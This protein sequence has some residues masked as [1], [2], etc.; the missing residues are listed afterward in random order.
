M[1]FSPGGSLESVLCP[2]GVRFNPSTAS[3]GPASTVDSHSGAAEP[4]SG[5]ILKRQ[6]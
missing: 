3:Q 1:H 4:F 5:L 2:L 6:V